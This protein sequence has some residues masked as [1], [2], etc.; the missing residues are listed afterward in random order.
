MKNA[1]SREMTASA[2]GDTRI[3]RTKPAFTIDGNPREMRVLHALL[4]RPMPREQ[5]DACAGAS[6]G[7]DLIFGLRERGLSLPCDRAPVIDRDGREVK[8]GIYRTTDG[9]RR[10]SRTPHSRQGWP[11]AV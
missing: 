4:R 1:R 11:M 7:P 5:V 9:D 2:E 3:V 10:A 8:R 6:N